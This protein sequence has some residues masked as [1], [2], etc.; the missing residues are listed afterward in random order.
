MKDPHVAA[1]GFTYEA[2]ALRSWLNSGHNTSPMTNLPLPHLTL[3]PNLAL[4]SAIKE[5]QDQQREQ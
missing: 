1:D 4:R 5:W 3:V 2:E